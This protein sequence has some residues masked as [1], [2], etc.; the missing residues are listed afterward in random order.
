M[1]ITV[2]FGRNERGL[3]GFDPDAEIDGLDF[4]LRHPSHARSEYVWN[5]L[6]APNRRLVAGVVER[7]VLQSFSDSSREP[8][9]VG[10]RRG[11]GREAWLPGRDGTFRRPAELSLDDLP[12]HLY[13]GTRGWP[14]PWA[15]SGP[16][17]ARPPA[18]RDAPEVL[19]GLSAHP[20]LV[21]LIERELANRAAARGE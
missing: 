4:A 6:L 8:G 13:P 5:V 21:A 18:S 19:W 1:T 12:P 7:S 2:D 16:W 11:R 17:W 3:D 14:R 15:C 10:D 20:D 9:Q